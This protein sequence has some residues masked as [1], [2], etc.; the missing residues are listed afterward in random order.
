VPLFSFYSKCD[1]PELYAKLRVETEPDEI[2]KIEN[3]LM[4]VLNDEVPFYTP[5]VR[6][7]YNVVSKRVGG[8]FKL[9]PN[10]RDSTMGIVD[11]IIP[12]K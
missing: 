3:S 1:I 8:G 11:W 4:K 10:D 9:Y 5:W 2:V 6:Q 7:T 12:P